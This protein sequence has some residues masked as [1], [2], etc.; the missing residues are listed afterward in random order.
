[1]GGNTFSNPAKLIFSSPTCEKE[2]LLLQNQ[3]AKTNDLLMYQIYLLVKDI[4]SQQK[5]G[6]SQRIYFE[7][8]LNFLLKSNW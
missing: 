2:T 1:M 7:V 6:C 5:P 4:N 8:W 3:F